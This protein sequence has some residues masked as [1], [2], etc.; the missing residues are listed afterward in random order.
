[1]S[2]LQLFAV[3]GV[4]MVVI[5]LVLVTVSVLELGSLG[6]AAMNVC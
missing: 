3:L 5:V 2:L 6:H 1:M 4:K